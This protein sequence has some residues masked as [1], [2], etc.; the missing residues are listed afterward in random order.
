MRDAI[1]I[2][3][4]V[5]AG[6][7]FCVVFAC[8]TIDEIQQMVCPNNTISFTSYLSVIANVGIFLATI[9]A[10][11]YAVKEYLNKKREHHT[12]LLAKYNQR[13]SSDNNITSVVSWMLKV[14]IVD[15]DGKIVGANPYRCNYSPGVHKKEMFMRFFEELYLH[16]KDGNI[17]KEDAFSFF[18]YYAIIFE[19][20]KDFRLDI[21]DYKTKE[22][23][24]EMQEGRLKREYTYLWSGFRKFIYEMNVILKEKEKEYK[25]NKK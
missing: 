7:V 1:I 15:K 13:Y 11:M 19:K 16:I 23:L 12:K 6:I 25:T 17:K 8:T 21:T 9:F 5:I 2:F 24:K 3:C 10:T 14:A 22:E 4:F 20:Y 18:A